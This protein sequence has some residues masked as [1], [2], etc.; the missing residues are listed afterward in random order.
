MLYTNVGTLAVYL[1]PDD[2]ITVQ[3]GANN[4]TVKLMNAL[5]VGVMVDDTLKFVYA[6]VT[7][8]GNGNSSGSAADTFQAVSSATAVASTAVLTNLDTYKATAT[9][10]TSAPYSGG[11]ATSLGN[12][13]TAGLPVKIFVWLEGTDAQAILGESDNDLQG[14]NVSLK[15]VGVL[16]S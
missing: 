16:A 9:G 8:S 5:R 7:E 1:D 2:P 11:S 10:D 15:Y 6:P 4:P 13:D 14:I 3:Y 12:A